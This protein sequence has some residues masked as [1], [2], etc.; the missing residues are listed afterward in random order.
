[1][2]QGVGG[3]AGVPHGRGMIQRVNTSADTKICTKCGRVL[4]AAELGSET[5]ILTSECPHCAW[6]RLC[7]LTEADLH[8]IAADPR[9]PQKANPDVFRRGYRRYY[10]EN[11]EKIRERL[12]RRFAAD[13]GHEGLLVQAEAGHVEF[14]AQVR[15]HRTR[16][17]GAGGSHT[18]EDVKRLYDEQG[19]RCF[20]CGKELNGVYELDHKTPLSRG[21]T[22]WPENLCCA[23]EWCSCRKQKKTAEDFMEYL[24]E[25][26]RCS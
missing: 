14:T 13:P 9:S 7:Q 15:K 17:H 18:I 26:R 20:Y 1:V 4:P 3:G 6:E 12:R 24:T 16:R 23:C 22:D 25:L 19:G 11:R 5:L 10:G 21:G 2:L 8:K